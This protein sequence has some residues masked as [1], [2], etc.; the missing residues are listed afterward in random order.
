MDY[1]LQE[2]IVLGVYQLS[3]QEEKKRRSE[4]RNNAGYLEK[5]FGSLVAFFEKGK[6]VG[7]FPLVCLVLFL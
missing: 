1:V 6:N 5:W 2:I 4:L 3:I 7:H